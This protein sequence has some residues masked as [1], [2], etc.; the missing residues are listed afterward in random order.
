MA[1]QSEAV[2]QVIIDASVKSLLLAAVAAVALRLIASSNAN[3]KHR[4]WSAVLAAMLLLPVLSALTP[5]LFVTALPVGLLQ[6]R[7]PAPTSLALPE[8]AT[9]VARPFEADSG[10]DLIVDGLRA[11]TSAASTPTSGQALSPSGVSTATAL[12]EISSVTASDSPKPNVAQITNHTVAGAN[13]RFGWASAI[14]AMYLVGFC[15]FLARLAVGYFVAHRL[16]RRATPIERS[17]SRKARVA[18]SESLRVPVTVGVVHPTIVLPTDWET[19]DDDLLAAVLA[20]EEAHIDRR[21]LL[22]VW[23]AELNRCVYWFHPLAWFL[24]RQLSQL[25][26]QCCDDAVIA[27]SGDRRGYAR[28]LVEIAQRLQDSSQ[29]VVAVGLAMARTSRVEARVRQILD[30]SRP[31]ARRLTKRR[32]A[33][34]AA[35]ATPVVL[36]AAALRAADEPQTADLPQTV[37]SIESSTDDSTSSSTADKVAQPEPPKD[38]KSSPAPAPV[39]ELEKLIVAVREQEDRFDNYS[40]KV[41]LS[42]EFSPPPEEKPTSAISFGPS[43]L[44]GTSEV[45]RQIVQGRSFELRGEDSTLLASGEKPTASRTSVCD[46]AKTVS[47]ESGVV[48]IHAGRVEPPQMLAPH[49]WGVFHLSVN[50]PLSVYLGGTEAMKSCAKVRRHPAEHGAIYEFYK[51]E[52]RLLGGEQVDGL[53]CVKVRVQRWHYT[54]EPPIIQYLWLAKER[55]YHVAKTRTA[56]VEKFTEVDRE[57]S[58]VTKWRQLA[59]DLWAPVTVEVFNI[60]PALKKDADGNKSDRRLIVEEIAFKPRLPADAFVLPNIPATLPA[61]AFSADGQLSDSPQHPQPVAADPAVT[62]ETILTRLAAEEAKYARLEVVSHERYTMLNQHELSMGGV[63]TRSEAQQ[64]SVLQGD[65]LLFEETVSIQTA[66]GKSSTR[67]VREAHDVDVTR[68]VHTQSTGDAEPK[69]QKSASLLLGKRNDLKAIQPHT[70]VFRSERSVQSLAAFLRSGWLDERNGYRSTVE[71]VGDEQVGELHCHK[72]RCEFPRAARKTANSFFYLWLA[73]D[74]NLLAVREQWFDPGWHASLPTGLHYLDN[75]REIQ[76]GLWYPQ[77]TV[78]LCFQRVS[79]V[80]LVANRVPLQWRRETTIDSVTVDPEIE[81]SLF[82]TVDVPADTRVGV[83]DEKGQFLAEFKQP[84]AGNIEVSAD[85]LAAMRLKAQASREE[86]E[87]RQKQLDALIGQ[88]APELPQE[89]W[90]NSKPLSWRQLTGKVVIVDFWAI[91]CGPC[92]PDINRLAQVH[93]AWQENVVTD[94]MI[95]GVHTAGSDRD[96]VAKAAKEKEL[97][98]PIV[99]DS[100]ATKGELSWGSLYS[101]FAVR[102]IPLA[103][104]VDGAGK[105]VAHGRLEEMLSKASEVAAAEKEAKD[106]VKPKAE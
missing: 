89:T 72:L 94:R 8:I 2:L 23:A 61:F 25:A 24:R 86:T 57:E 82:T 14:A 15:L 47:I 7:S 92:E 18:T 27:V 103:I 75:L 4:V 21:D 13:G 99:I 67:G 101:K 45:N 98:Y 40:A 30:E 69:S 87:R 52:A 64:R 76:P 22:T 83:Q 105:I 77:Q 70:L 34:I 33:S 106:A 60:S 38:D 36:V 19:W 90:L 35:V 65:Q 79:R 58:R 11:S 59:D 95:I 56:Y 68:I 73:R 44:R 62:L 49:D 63:Y 37:A 31:L 66:D 48:M 6:L 20:H 51:A 9:D 39:T 29:R 93:K 81:K 91:W 50:F 55:N 12:A 88:P 85:E 78:S 28:R 46:G 16:V 5:P 102:Q 84:Q 96:A 26:E 10:N 74:R 97:D 43:Q 41:A 32:A 80:G 100:P 42:R 104:V 54:K 1:L 3:F 17:L 53:D 71:Y